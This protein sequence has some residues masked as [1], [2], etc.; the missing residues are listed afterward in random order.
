VVGMVGCE[1]TRMLPTK[2]WPS[3]NRSAGLSSIATP[4]R[5]RD[6]AGYKKVINKT[7]AD[8]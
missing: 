7:L 1:E 6:L 4:L 8:D 5:I 2:Q 3:K